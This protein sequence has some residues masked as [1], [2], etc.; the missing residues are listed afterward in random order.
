MRRRLILLVLFA[1]S[2][3]SARPRDE[4][5]KCPESR[6]KLCLTREICSFDRPRECFVCQCSAPEAPAKYTPDLQGPITR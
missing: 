6:N 2:C 5:T 3:A 1:V 4:S